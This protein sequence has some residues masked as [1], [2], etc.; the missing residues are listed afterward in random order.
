MSIFLEFEIEE[1]LINAYLNLIFRCSNIFL[2]FAPATNP[3]IQYHVFT[4]M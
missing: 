4:F 1:G 3:D 2:K